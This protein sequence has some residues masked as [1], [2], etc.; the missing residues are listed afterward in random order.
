[1]FLLSFHHRI[2]RSKHFAHHLVL[3]APEAASKDLS[4]SDS[5]I[6]TVKVTVDVS[7]ESQ[8][9][10]VFRAQI[11][12]EQQLLSDHGEPLHRREALSIFTL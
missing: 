4:A 3:V 8:S 1:L 12:L 5:K 7:R 6:G 9:P 11:V 10:R 2:E